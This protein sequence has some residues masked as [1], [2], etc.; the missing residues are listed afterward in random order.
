MEKMVSKRLSTRKKPPPPNGE[1]NVATRPPFY[2]TIFIL[3]QMLH[4]SWIFVLASHNTNI[5]LLF[6]PHH[7]NWPIFAFP[8]FTRLAAHPLPYCMYVY[9]PPNFSNK[10]PNNETLN[11]FHYF[12]AFLAN[13]IIKFT[14]NIL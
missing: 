6:I 8:F 11:V 2:S 3:Q 12:F 7:T 13:I 9:P 1:I 5:F 4:I 10:W 14:Q